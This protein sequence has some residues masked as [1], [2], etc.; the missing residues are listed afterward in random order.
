MNLSA[1]HFMAQIPTHQLCPLSPQGLC[2]SPGCSPL[3]L[4]PPAGLIFFSISNT[5]QCN[6]TVPPPPSQ[7][8][9]THTHTHTYAYTQGTLEHARTCVHT[10][11]YLSLDIILHA[12]ILKVSKGKFLQLQDLLSSIKVAGELQIS[13]FLA[14]NYF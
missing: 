14:T 2:I 9:H 4:Q 11:I 6:A 1:Q 13:I 8:T 5:E 7:Y 3:S 12:S 10:H